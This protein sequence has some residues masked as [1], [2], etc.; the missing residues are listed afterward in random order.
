MGNRKECPSGWTASHCLS[1]SALFSH[2][3]AAQ[4]PESLWPMSPRWEHSPAPDDPAASHFHQNQ[5][6]TSS[7]ALTGSLK[8]GYIPL[9]PQSSSPVRHRPLAPGSSS[10]ARPPP[11]PLPTHRAGFTWLSFSHCS[12]SVP[13]PFLITSWP[14]SVS[15]TSTG[16]LTYHLFTRASSS[17]IDCELLESW[18]LFALFPAEPLLPELCLAQ[19]KPWIKMFVDWI[20]EWIWGNLVFYY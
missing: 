15:M 9:A 3:L 12:I 10:E 8:A 2:V 1:S 20:H 6:Q 7:H 5:V 11:L 17:L 4:Q 19:H 18:A 13:A 16:Y 14:F